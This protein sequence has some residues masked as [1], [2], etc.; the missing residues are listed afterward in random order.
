LKLL[1][2]ELISGQ[3]ILLYSPRRYGKSSLMMMVLKQLQEK[4]VLTAFIDMYGCI[5][6]SD[7]VDKLVEKTVIAAYGKMDRIVGFLKSALSGLRAEVT[8][9]PDGSI[10]ISY[11]KEI[12]SVGESHVLPELLDAPEKLAKAKNKRLVVVFDEFQE[13]ENLD[14]T[15]LENL[16]R[17]H[18]QHHEN[19]TYVFM[20]SKRHLIEHMFGDSNR[21]FYRFAKPFPLGKIPIEEFKSFIIEKFKHTEVAID[22]SIVASILAFTDGHP[23]FTQQLCHEIWNAAAGEESVQEQDVED[24]TA[25]ILKI[26]NDLFITKWDSLT[27]P[28]KKLLVALSKEDGVSAVF[29]MDFI[30]KYELSSP[31]HV[32]RAIEPLLRDGTIEKADGTYVMTDI[33]FREWVENRAAR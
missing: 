14:G 15:K 10:R 21:P 17:T 9:E 2:N 13:I 7:L 20:G 4:D 30:K 18:F 22:D 8:I 11:R 5:S 1:V 19:V 6:L 24:A 12:A 31:S 23:Y 27:T 26:H 33:F 25:T 16:M 32:A 29:S 3:N 28:Q